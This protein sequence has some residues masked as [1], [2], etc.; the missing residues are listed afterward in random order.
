MRI[1]NRMNKIQE[2]YDQDFLNQF[3]NC[4]HCMDKTDLKNGL[5]KQDTSI[6]GYVFR[7]VNFFLI[8]TINKKERLKNCSG[9]VKKMKYNTLKISHYF[10]A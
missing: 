9:L 1:L 6:L 4:I 10:I 2:K 8:N 7:L 5:K 3:Q